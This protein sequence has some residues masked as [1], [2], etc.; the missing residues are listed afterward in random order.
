M[1]P[2]QLSKPL[3]IQ[4]VVYN[5]EYDARIG[6]YNLLWMNYS[7]AT[8]PVT[9]TIGEKIY[10]V[11]SVPAAVGVE[12]SKYTKS[13]IYLDSLHGSRQ[14]QI[15]SLWRLAGLNQFS[16]TTRSPFKSWV[17]P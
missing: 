10:V 4:K 17:V 14:I 8:F 6:D 1:I 2:Y 9:L 5:G 3:I 12:T 11:V 7:D 13:I 15:R 16:R